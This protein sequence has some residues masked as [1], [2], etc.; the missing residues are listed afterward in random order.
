MFPSL[1]VFSETHGRERNQPRHW[2]LLESRLVAGE[3]CLGIVEI[4]RRCHGR[5]HEQKSYLR[6]FKRPS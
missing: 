1:S 3:R 5:L 2:V 6:T 4:D